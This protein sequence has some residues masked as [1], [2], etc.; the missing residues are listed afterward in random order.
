MLYMFKTFVSLLSGHGSYLFRLHSKSLGLWTV[1]TVLGIFVLCMRSVQNMQER[2]KKNTYICSVVCLSVRP[3][4]HPS[5]H[6][7]KC[8]NRST[9]LAYLDMNA[10]Q[11]ETAQIS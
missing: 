2:N 8:D 5:M 7:L 4:I 1:L 9:S 10:E 6:L 11:L 3:S